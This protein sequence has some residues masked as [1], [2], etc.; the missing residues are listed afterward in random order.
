MGA[1]LRRL[2]KPASPGPRACQRLETWKAEKL[3][4]AQGECTFQPDLS[5]SSSPRPCVEIPDLD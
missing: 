3:A 1:L 2:A 5:R 4:A